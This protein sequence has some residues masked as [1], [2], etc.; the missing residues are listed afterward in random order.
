[1]L[2]DPQLYVAC[3]L[4]GSRDVLLDLAAAAASQDLKQG[5][6]MIPSRF[7]RRRNPPGTNP[8]A[9]TLLEEGFGH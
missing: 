5:S 8:D 3:E 7:G 6:T 2:R 1:M 4:R 9:K